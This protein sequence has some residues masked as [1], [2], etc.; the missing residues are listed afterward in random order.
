MSR[1]VLHVRVSGEMRYNCGAALFKSTPP[2][3]RPQFNSDD[4]ANRAPMCPKCEA[5]SPDLR[6]QAREAA[7]I[8]R[9]K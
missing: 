8:A 5:L 6:R 7:L 1:R 2:H 4:D 9:R 3:H